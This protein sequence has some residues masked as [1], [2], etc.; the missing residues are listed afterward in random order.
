MRMA[1][2]LRFEVF[3]RERGFSNINSGGEITNIRVN[4]GQV[5]SQHNIRFSVIRHCCSLAFGYIVASL[6]FDLSDR[7]SMRGIILRAGTVLFG[8][9]SYVLIGM[10]IAAAG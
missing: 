2:G 10:A 8:T 5:I 7:G 3:A 1:P 9:A 4:N 6:F